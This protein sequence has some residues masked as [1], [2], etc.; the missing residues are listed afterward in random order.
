MIFIRLTIPH[1]LTVLNMIFFFIVLFLQE[2]QQ[3]IHEKYSDVKNSTDSINKNAEYNK[4]SLYRC[5]LYSFWIN[6]LNTLDTKSHES[7]SMTTKHLYYIHVHT[8]C[9]VK[10]LII[11]NPHF[12]ECLYLIY[13]FLYFFGKTERHVKITQTRIHDKRD[14]YIFHLFTSYFRFNIYVTSASLFK[15]FTVFISLKSLQM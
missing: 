9:N 5:L 6:F 1:A 15:L 3:R 8:N 13:R 4:K 11:N 12:C 14:Y 10:S 7:F 2:K